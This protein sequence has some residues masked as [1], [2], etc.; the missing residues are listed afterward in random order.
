MDI[1]NEHWSK[2]S[3]EP[4]GILISKR[5]T[6][7]RTKLATYQ[8][9]FQQMKIPDMVPSTDPIAQLVTISTPIK[10]TDLK[11]LATLKE[12]DYAPQWMQLLLE[13]YM[14]MYRSGSH[15]IPMLR[16]DIPEGRSLLNSLVRFYSKPV[17]D[18]KHMWEL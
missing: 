14:K 2:K 11:L 1:L 18:L 4:I 13:H 8:A 7:A 5:T 9:T 6:N 17:P 16:D 3:G 12:S 15:S 10:P